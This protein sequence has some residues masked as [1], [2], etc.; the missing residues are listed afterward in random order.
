[1]NLPLELSPF[2]M[3]LHRSPTA[4]FLVLVC[5]LDLHILPLGI[6]VDYNSELRFILGSNVPAQP[7]STA[8]NTTI[9]RNN[10]K[11]QYFHKV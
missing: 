10:I 4:G 1:M 9:V 8:K 5:S 11:Y 6:F 7:E 2:D 3:S